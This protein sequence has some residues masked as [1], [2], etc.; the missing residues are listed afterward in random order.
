MNEYLEQARAKWID[1]PQVTS[2]G[3]G[4]RK[5]PAGQELQ[6][7]YQP[8][9][10]EGTETF[11]RRGKGGDIGVSPEGM[12]PGEDMPLEG[13]DD[14]F[15]VQAR[16]IT[17]A[18]VSGSL[19]TSEAGDRIIELKRMIR[20]RDMAEAKAQGQPFGMSR[21]YED[22]QELGENIYG[23]KSGGN[24]PL[25]DILPSEGGPIGGGPINPNIRN[26]DSMKEVHDYQLRVLEPMVHDNIWGSQ[27]SD[28]GATYRYMLEGAGDTFR[29]I[30]GNGAE[31]YIEE[32]L[33]R[34]VKQFTEFRPDVDN[35]PDEAIAAGKSMLELVEAAPVYTA[36]QEAAA[37]LI[38]GIIDRDIDVIRE[39][40]DRIRAMRPLGQREI[41]LM[42]SLNREVEG[43]NSYGLRNEF[44]EPKRGPAYMFVWSN[45]QAKWY[46]GR[47]VSVGKEVRLDANQFIGYGKKADLES[48][49]ERLDPLP[50]FSEGPLGGSFE[51]RSSQTPSG[52]GMPMR[53]DIT[54]YLGKIGES[55][56]NKPSQEPPSYG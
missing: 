33:K 31:D 15:R 1:D 21:L 34:I 41:D 17:Q 7:P 54:D 19:S 38:I 52:G 32:K 35:L 50:L 40:V 24:M 22:I 23:T 2:L 43:L 5:G 55:E 6:P 46:V 36:R 29:E 51:Y 56:T 20:E 39:A 27:S 18:H 8:F 16:V 14:W 30:A 3:R 10:V 28:A 48:V 12:T 26:P 13:T 45:A 25:Q 37:D 42:G 11:L 53:K 44:V 9:P 47:R 49:V 4:R